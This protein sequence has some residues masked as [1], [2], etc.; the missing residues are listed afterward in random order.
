M[1]VVHI[2]KITGIAG[3]EGHLLSLLPALGARG[4]DARMLVLDQPDRRAQSFCD[5]MTARGVPIDVVP[6]ARHVDPLLVARIVGRLRAL[7]PDIVH[8]HLVH[9]DLYGLAAARR[10]G[11]RAT[12][13][14]RHDNN[15][16]RRRV[17]LRWLNRRATLQA[18]R[19]VAISHAIARFVIDVE[20]ADPRAVATIHYGLG[21]DDHEGEPRDVVRETR[22]LAP[23]GMLVGVVGRLIEQKGIDVLLDAWP[24]VMARHPDARLVVVGDGA[25]RGR[26]SERATR[27][28]LGASVVFAGWMPMAREVMSAC[29]VVVIPSRWEGFGLVALEAMAC[30]RPVVASDVDAL[31]EIVE[32]RETGLLVPPEDAPALSAAINELLDRPEWATALGMAGRQRLVDHF[33]VEKM[34]S[35]THDLYDKVMEEVGR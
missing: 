19:I 29:D 35:A 6:I 12:I 15:P 16:F 33:S 8:T 18:R 24:G 1:R 3:A 30:A 20:G 4:I 17:P 11:I 21:P 34:A 2:S 23:T 13:A 10:A 28:G 27:L 14:S 25:L 5:A 22:G 32:P 7:D 9:A 26:L 31:P